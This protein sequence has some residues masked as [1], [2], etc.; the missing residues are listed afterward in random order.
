MR[1][2]FRPRLML[3][4]ISAV[5]WFGAVRAAERSPAAMADAARKGLR[6][7]LTAFGRVRS[8]SRWPGG[9]GWR[10]CTI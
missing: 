9:L 7:D 2:F 6:F 3:V 5:A 4:V 1:A 8:A 10:G